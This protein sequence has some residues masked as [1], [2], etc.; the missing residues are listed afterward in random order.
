MVMLYPDQQLF[1]AYS[2]L[3]AST[4]SGS[5][6]GGVRKSSKKSKITE[7]SEKAKK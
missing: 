5:F 6:F 2:V 3:F 1:T 7:I 4:A